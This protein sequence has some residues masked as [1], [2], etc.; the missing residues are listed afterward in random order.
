MS[1][2]SREGWAASDYSHPHMRG[3]APNHPPSPIP[4]SSGGV[5]STL[6]YPSDPVPGSSRET[7]GDLTGPVPGHDPRFFAGFRGGYRY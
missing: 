1:G 6:D 3:S 5:W 4:G 7:L 2:P